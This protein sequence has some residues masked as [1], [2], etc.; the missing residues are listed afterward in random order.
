MK[1]LG[2][3]PI[4]TSRTAQVAGAAFQVEPLPKGTTDPVS[5]TPTKIN[6]TPLAR[7]PPPALERSLDFRIIE[8]KFGFYIKEYLDIFSP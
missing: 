1:S 8:K 5:H 4:K 2:T 6:F 3:I 7:C